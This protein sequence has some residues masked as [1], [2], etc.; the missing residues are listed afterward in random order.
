M[1]KLNFPTYTFRLRKTLKYNEIFDPIR[2]KFV[3]LTPEEWVR[4]HVLMYLINDLKYPLGL[5]GVESKIKYNETNLRSDVVVFKNTSQPFIII[6]CKAPTVK[7]S[8]NTIDQVS[9][10]N[11]IL[12][13]PWLMATNGQEHF[14]YQ[15]IFNENRFQIENQLPIFNSQ[16]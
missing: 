14:I 11:F 15:V 7:I 16:K 9:K 1:D 5:I 6:E 4:Q 2:K 10:Y 3:R 8:Q 12:K 13:A